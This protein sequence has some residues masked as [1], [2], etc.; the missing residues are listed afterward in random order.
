M[1]FLIRTLL[2]SGGT[3]NYWLCVVSGGPVK[4]VDIKESSS[5]LVYCAGTIP[6]NTGGPV[7]APVAYLTTLNADGTLNSAFFYSSGGGGSTYYNFNQ[8]VLASS[9]NV[10]GVMDTADSGQ[11]TALISIDMPSAVLNY[12]TQLGDS[13]FQSQSSGTGIAQDSANNIYI[14]GHD[15]ETYPT[16]DNCA[17]IYKYDSSGAP[18]AYN[19]FGLSPFA[20]TVSAKDIAVDSSDY[21][22]ITGQSDT[23]GFI[24]R[25]NSIGSSAFF[26]KKI[27][28]A[29]G[30]AI[31]V[32]VAVDSTGNSYVVSKLSSGGSSALL[33]KFDSAGTIVWQRE[34]SQSPSLNVVPVAIALD[35]TGNPYLLINYSISTLSGET[36]IAVVKYD[37]SGSLIWQTQITTSQIGQTSPIPITSVSTAANIVSYHGSFG[38]IGAP[39]PA[40]GYTFLAYGFLTVGFNG[41]FTVQSADPT[42]INVSSAVIGASSIGAVIIDVPYVLIASR[43]MIDSSGY[44]FIGGANGTFSNGPLDSNSLAIKIDIYNSVLGTFGYYTFAPAT[45]TDAAGTATFGGPSY[46]NGLAPTVS[47]SA[48]SDG[49]PETPTATVIT[50]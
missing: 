27:T 37:A 38:I 30:T 33:C 7:L 18:I 47:S 9:T 41:Q 43:M 13:L 17:F 42:K 11:K 44:I 40:A 10:I 16:V 50:I 14:C 6:V 35:S 5:G 3:G 29:S 28:G 12:Q 23:D 8:I 2:S 25:F 26:E 21:V 24:A 1:T 22:Y 36:G 45:F 48:I 19:A 15:V 39:L 32:G 31:G 49:T 46:T 4:F 34:L 20:L